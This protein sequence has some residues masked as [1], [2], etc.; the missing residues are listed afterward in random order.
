MRH[1]R[2]WTRPSSRARDTSSPWVVL[3]P[4]RPVTPHMRQPLPGAGGICSPLVL[5]GRLPLSHQGITPETRAPSWVPRHSRLCWGHPR[6]GVARAPSRA[7]GRSWPP[8]C[9]VRTLRLG[10]GWAGPGRPTVG[11]RHETGDGGE[12]DTS[13]R[14][15][16]ARSCTDTSV[17]TP[18]S[19]LTGREGRAPQ[20]A[21]TWWPSRDNWA[22]QTERGD[23]QGLCPPR[24]IPQP[25]QG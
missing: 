8:D 15:H 23:T 1:R 17:V 10:T 18:Q 5:Q 13:E 24:R 11:W 19:P 14:L 20:Q 6:R 25:S 4:P 16:G 12:L 7:R 9:R 2:P 3:S 21:G 22:P